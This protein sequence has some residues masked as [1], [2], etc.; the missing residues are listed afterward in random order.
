MVKG[1]VCKRERC[2]VV[3]CFARHHGGQIIHVRHRV[4][5]GRVGVSVWGRR[6]CVNDVAVSKNLSTF[7]PRG[8]R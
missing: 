6:D 5:L 1:C 3:S 2:G 4:A 8:A 7:S